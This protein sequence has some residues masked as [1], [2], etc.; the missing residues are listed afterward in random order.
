MADFD[1]DAPTKGLSREEL[2]PKVSFAGKTQWTD[3]C[4]AGLFAKR[5]RELKD[6]PKYTSVYHGTKLVPWQ[7][8][9]TE[10]AH[11]VK[12]L[13]S[14]TTFDFET[15]ILDNP[16]TLTMDADTQNY[17]HMSKTGTFN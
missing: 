11:L 10:E 6:N 7:G 15:C 17:I 1:L 13:R 5:F 12:E 8:L 14:S 16:A 9:E 2:L 4:K 3:L